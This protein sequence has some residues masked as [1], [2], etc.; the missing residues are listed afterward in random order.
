M[1]I[2]SVLLS[3][4][5]F[6]ISF[7]AAAASGSNSE[8]V[9]LGRFVDALTGAS[10]TSPTSDSWQEVKVI[11]PGLGRTGTSSLKL[12]LKTPCKRHTLQNV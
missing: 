9:N 1:A 8:D 7:A 4:V 6:C 2:F 12:A 3:F 5:S 11:A 10:L